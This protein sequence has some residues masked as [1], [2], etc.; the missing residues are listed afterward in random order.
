MADFIFTANVEI[1][2]ESEED[3]QIEL[4]GRMDKHDICW[5]LLEE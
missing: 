5:E 4:L 1:D 3:A 2:A